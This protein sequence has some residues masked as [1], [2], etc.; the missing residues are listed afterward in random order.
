MRW[1]ESEFKTAFPRKDV[2]G[3]FMSRSGSLEDT[4][5]YYALGRSP[6]FSDRGIELE[7]RSRYCSGQLS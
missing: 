2:N 3:S 5:E 1:S 4:E 6:C 7:R